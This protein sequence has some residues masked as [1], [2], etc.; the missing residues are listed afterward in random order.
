VVAVKPGSLSPE[1]VIVIGGHF[2][3][4]SDDPDCDPD[5]LAPGGND[6]ASGT[7]A[8]I[9]LARVLAD[10]ETDLT[11]MFVA[12]GAEEQGILGSEHFAREAFDSGMNIR[13]MIN[14]DVVGCS[15]EYWEVRLLTEP[16]SVP[17]AEIFEAMAYQYTSLIPFIDDN[18]TSQPLSDSY[19][20][21]EF[22]YHTVFPIET[23]PCPNG[24]HSCDDNMENINI[25]Y[26]TQVSEMVYYSA[27]YISETPE[28]PRNFEVFNIGDGTLFLDWAPNI[29][30]DLVGYRI[31][32]GLESGDYDSVKIV[33]SAGDTL[34]NL[35]E[36]ATYYLALSAF[37]NEGYESILTEE[38]VIVPSSRP[39][40]PNGI[41][42]TSLG[43][44]IVLS[45][46]RNPI[47]LDLAGYRV[48]RWM[49]DEPSD[50]VSI[51]YVPDPTTTFS[52]HAAEPHILYGYHVTAVDSED[53]PNESDPTEAVF[54][55]LA[56]HDM[57]LLVVDN[58]GDGPG[59]PFS[60]TDEAVDEFYSSVLAGY[61]VSASW[62]VSD[63]LAAGRSL[64]D[65][66]TGLYS[67]VVWH[68]DIRGA[69]PA[70]SDTT[71]MRKYL[72]GGGNLWLSGWKLLA[73]IAGQG[74][75]FYI[76]E[77]GFVPEYVGIDS[78]RTTLVSEQDFIGAQ[79]LVEGFPT[80]QV[81]PEKVF[82]I[83][84]LYDM[85]VLLPPFVGSYPIY[86]YISSDSTASEYHGL[87]VAVA[88]SS[89]AYG[90]VMTDFPL[91]FMEEGEARSLAVAVMDLFGEPVS[92]A[93]GETVASLPRV[94]AL[95]Q[96]YPNPFNPSTTI[97]YDIPV[98]SGGSGVTITGSG[99][100]EG[101][102]TVNVR[103]MIYDLRGRLVRK[104]LDQD[105]EPGRYQAHWDGR[106]DRGA[107]VSSGIYL[108]RIEAGEFVSTK[109]MVMLD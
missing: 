58:T 47:D 97:G 40:T 67:T 83:G 55:C 72:L 59:V 9:E 65:Y 49:E 42:S 25:P 77:E 5:T 84:A 81:N 22:G 33:Y 94:F 37:D 46:E 106:D 73:F 53:P 7:A 20:F 11:I 34:G 32:Y 57:G 10:L 64:M 104:L 12:F 63:S 62:D 61:D 68:M 13:L 88:D 6:N 93:G 89:P 99:S 15:D 85:E 48:Y 69:S 2:D 78:A 41:T 96:N 3:S 103:L 54:G 70:A 21:Y 29:E 75:P 91:Y 109:K 66:D 8:T 1:E 27:Q 50:T 98:V 31:Y 51:A 82:P 45:W 80:L 71:T 107:R 76:F 38:V 30:S 39:L 108:Y 56:T 79:S 14:L 100:S 26:L 16:L 90:F 101:A 35:I 74:E 36:D 19:W 17:Y 86:S 102:G 4:V 95:T 43:S 105:R 28:T 52:D 23:D 60:P 44:A 87:P 18:G 24:I 92:I